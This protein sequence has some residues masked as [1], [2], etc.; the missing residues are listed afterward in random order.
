MAR[1]L[2]VD[3]LRLV[4]ALLEQL[5]PLRRPV[6][7][8]HELLVEDMADGG[9]GSLRFVGKPNARMYSA[10]PEL[11]FFDTDG[12]WVSA[13]VNLDADGDL[14]EL[15]IFKGDFSP[16]NAIPKDLGV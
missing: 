9:M 8:L 15:D 6:A 14:F 1:H 12:V 11:T 2:R 10:T 7:E 5:P 3:E 13:T 16:L 4:K